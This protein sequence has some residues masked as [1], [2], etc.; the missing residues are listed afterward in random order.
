MIRP[1]IPADLSRVMEIWLSCN[2]QAHWF[3]DASYWLS[4]YEEVRE[5]YIPHSQTLVF[6]STGRI[7]GFASIF[8]HMFLGGLFV[9]PYAQSLGIGSELLKACKQC[10]PLLRLTVYEE[11]RRAVEFY[12]RSGF[13]IIREQTAP[14]THP[15]IE[16]LMEWRRGIEDSPSLS[17]SP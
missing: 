4:H 15:H 8:K 11:N 10:S 5:H 9:T 6:E 1:F 14:E 16:Y 7:L 13:Q 17:P 12:L 3:I 2:L